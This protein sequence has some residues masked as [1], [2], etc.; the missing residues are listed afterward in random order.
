MRLCTVG[1]GTHP[2]L[3]SHTPRRFPPPSLA[4]A[5]LLTCFFFSSRICV[6]L[7]FFVSLPHARTRARATFTTAN[8]FAPQRACLLAVRVM[9]GH[10]NAYATRLPGVTLRGLGNARLPARPPRLTDRREKALEIEV[11]HDIPVKVMPANEAS[12]HLPPKVHSPQVCQVS[13]VWMR[14]E[15]W[16]GY[17]E[18]ALFVRVS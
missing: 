5:S 18:Q 3:T 4:R 6:L 7:C 12:Y 13:S 9:D 17:I 2:A 15:N 14:C 1:V 11:V 8:Y 10:F 16:E